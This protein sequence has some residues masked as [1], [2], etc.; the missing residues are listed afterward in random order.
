MAKRKVTSKKLGVD[1]VRL[2]DFD[3]E[4]SLEIVRKVNIINFDKLI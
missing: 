2:S 4:S 1:E 3:D